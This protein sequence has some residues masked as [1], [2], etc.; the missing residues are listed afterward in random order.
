MLSRFTDGA[1]QVLTI[2]Q[3]KAEEFGHNFIGSEHLLLGLLEEGQS[4][5]AKALQ[6][7]GLESKALEK[8]ILDEDGRGAGYVTSIEMTPRTKRILQLA[9]DSANQMQHNYVGAEHILLGILR[10]GG[11][12][13]VSILQRFGIRGEDIVKTI[14][15]LIGGADGKGDSKD[16]AKAQGNGNLGELDGFATDLNEQAKQGKIDPVI[17]R[18]NE[19]NR[20]I[21]ILSRRTK[22]NPVLIGEPGVGKTAIAEGLAQRIVSQNVPEILRNKRIISLSLTAMVAGAKYRGEFEE[23]LKKAIDEV[24]KHDDMIIFIDELHTLIGAGAS[25]GSMDAANI[26]K[27]ALARGTFQVIGATTL[28]EYK[29]HI[30]KDA[31]LERRFQPVL[32]GEPSEEEAL[33]ILTGL[34]DRYEAFHKAKITDAALKA[35]VELSSRY[36]SDRFLPDKAIDVMDEAASKVRMKVFTAP[37]D[38]KELEQRLA[39]IQKEKE[40]AVVAQNFEKAATLRDEEKKIADEIEAKQS[41]RSK[42]DEE[43]LVVTE[44]DIASVVS[45]WTGVPVAKLA[46]EE[47]KRLIRLEDELHKRVVG[48]DEAVVAV[49]KAV[50]RARA[51]LKDPK[52]PIGSFLFLGPT[53]VG[54]TEL[55]R[56]LAANLFGDENAMIRLDMS[57]YMEKHTISRL[58]GAPPGY[59]GYDEGGQLT[60]AVRRK[61]YSVILFD[62]VEKAHADFFN[63]LLQVLDDGR[64]TDNQGRTVD[65]RNTVII[66]TSNLGSNY[67]KE[68]SAAMGFLAAKNKD[69]AEKTADAKFEEAK[70]NTM[71]AVKRH[72]RPEFLNRIDEMIVFHPL[73]GEDLNKIV[74]ILLKGVTDRL[75][76]RNV[77]LEVSPEALAILVKEGSDFAFGARPLKRAIQRLIEDPISDLILKGDVVDG[78]TIKAE[79]KDDDIVM[80]V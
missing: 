14:N 37:P 35:A 60:D 43:K 73:K 45:Q 16:G 32:V 42:A 24:Q 31:A 79:A 13:A 3:E 19:I 2:A 55:A 67:L 26:L 11:G 21:Q 56:S 6:K 9:V 25:E 53:G 15:G 30:E 36:I 27:P 5:A 29:K 47:S 72:F 17:G 66:M 7:L 80:T 54:K 33:Q 78:T 57:E 77:T 39:S 64:L 20:V 71:D 69:N 34:R 40:E 70:K 4:V 18:D 58:V 62:E 1:Q 46:E 75:A 41:E 10:D 68:D 76:E 23:R 22:N 52:R 38:V 63:I 48:Q 65:F 8:A 59:V 44:D 74:T 28:D 50:R 61:P 51:G 49:A 12:I